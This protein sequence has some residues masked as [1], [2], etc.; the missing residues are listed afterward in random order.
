MAQKAL[1]NACS[2]TGIEAHLI[3]ESTATIY[4][5]VYEKMVKLRNLQ[6]PTIVAFIDIGHSKT[7]VTIARFTNEV[8]AEILIHDSDLNLGGRDLDWKVLE[9]IIDE[10]QKECNTES[11]PKDSKKC[12][13]KMLESAEKARIALSG[14]T[15]A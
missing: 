4:N 6:Q 8:Q 2:I 15:E 10:F 9:F 5:Y 11:N 13:L 1:L 7:T 12:C 3:D 14:D